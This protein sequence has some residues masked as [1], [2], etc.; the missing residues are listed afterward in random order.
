MDKKDFT[1]A[2]RKSNLYFFLLQPFSSNVSVSPWQET[3]HNGYKSQV[4]RLLLVEV[5]NR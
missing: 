3:G 5:M 4:P 2:G 1:T